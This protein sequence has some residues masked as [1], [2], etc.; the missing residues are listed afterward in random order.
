VG[1]WTVGL[2]GLLWIIDHVVSIILSF[3]R[4]SAWFQSFRIQGLRGSLR[5]LYDTHRSCGLWAAPLTLTVAFTGMTLS[6]PETSRDAVRTVSPVTDRLHDTWPNVAPP[7]APITVEAAM[8]RVTARSRIDSVRLFPDHAAYAVRTF[9]RRDPDDQGRLWTYVSMTDGRILGRRHDN[10]ATAGD[11]F[12]AWQYPLHSG[13]AFG[14]VGQLLVAA[15]GVLTMF[16]MVS[17]ILLWRRRARPK[18]GKQPSSLA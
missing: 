15:S 13:K 10:G 17:G 4:V 18:S 16:L 1:A 14:L 11:Q 7:E 8:D 5:R 6:W 9:D 2:I 3:P 12:F